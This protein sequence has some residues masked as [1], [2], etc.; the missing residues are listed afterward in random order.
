M[1]NLTNTPFDV[2]ETYVSLFFKEHFK[3]CH[4]PIQQLS[5]P[6]WKVLPYR[7]LRGKPDVMFDQ[8]REFWPSCFDR[9]QEICKLTVFEEKYPIQCQLKQPVVLHLY[10]QSLRHSLEDRA[11]SARSD[12]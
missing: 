4:T 2:L 1:I 3:K 8:E 5:L 7:S 6:D 10:S 11:R 9:Q 12:E